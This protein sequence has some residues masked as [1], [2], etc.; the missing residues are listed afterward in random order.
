MFLFSLFLF[1]FYFLVP[2][3]L[4]TRFKNISFI[5]NN[6]NLDWLWDF[7]YLSIFYARG[8]TLAKLNTLT[9]A[10]RPDTFC[11]VD[12]AHIN[13]IRDLSTNALG[14]CDQTFSP[15]RRALIRDRRK[16]VSWYTGAHVF[17][18]YEQ[19]K[20]K[21][22]SLL[23]FFDLNE[24][25]NLTNDY[26]HDILVLQR[27]TISPPLLFSGRDILAFFLYV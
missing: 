21:E 3:L 9:N 10:D 18:V 2:V 5:S 19:M 13:Q 16:C 12:S 15:T 27:P 24:V 14:N 23:S 25:D 7:L 20:E 26:S 1:L 6:L 4:M 22:S 11:L 8:P 17:R